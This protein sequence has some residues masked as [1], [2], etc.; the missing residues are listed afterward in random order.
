[1]AD[2]Q[3]GVPVE[4]HLETFIDQEGEQTHLV[5]DEPGQL[6]KMGESIYLRYQEV[7]E[8][9]QKSIPVTLKIEGNG[10][11]QLTRDGDAK[12]KL[13]FADGKRIEARYRTP[14]GMFPVE[15]VTPMLDVRL[16]DRPFAG[17]VNINY[18]LFAGEQLLGNY[19]IRLQFTA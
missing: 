9:S 17:M 12:V 13:R 1:M 6:F 7:D 5:F 8:E 11:V 18:Q 14:Y 2:L 4:I 19:K 15:T 3:T 10:N 16:R